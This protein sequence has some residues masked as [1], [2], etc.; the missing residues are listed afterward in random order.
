MK[1]GNTRIQF[2]FVLG[3]LLLILGPVSAASL[4]GTY[5]GDSRPQALYF[6]TLV[7]TRDAVTA[8]LID[9]SPA[10]SGETKT[11]SIALSGGISDDLFTL[12]AD[13]WWSGQ[14]FS[15]KTQNGRIIL[16]FPT[17]GG[18]LGTITFVRGSEESFNKLLATW[19]EGLQARFTEQ[20]R[21]QKARETEARALNALADK[22]AHD[23]RT[24]R[25]KDIEIKVKDIQGDLD[26]ERKVLNELSK[27][28]G[29]LIREAEVRPMTCYQ[30][31]Q[32][33]GYAFH[34]TMGY[35]FKTTLGYE[36]KNFE[37]N[38]KA[39]QTLLSESP[40]VIGNTQEHARALDEAIKGR[41]FA[42]KVSLQPAEADEALRHYRELL[43][44]A[45]SSLEDFQ[46]RN[47]AHL[48]EANVRMRQGEEIVRETQA[49]VRCRQ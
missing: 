13:R 4:S 2:F 41:R 39:L 32:T 21:E 6:L 42:T 17:Q 19:K 26:G 10:G 24:I 15:G 31:F 45:R 37:R 35:T 44:Y 48:A 9:V 27:D 36:V 12:R 20:Q 46:G 11:D 38:M 7:Q 5:I 40:A 18:A 33:V 49:S 30:A 3:L 28:L 8:S 22:F 43:E 16:S 34:Q 14:V 1:F 47:D 25:S 29:N 23:L